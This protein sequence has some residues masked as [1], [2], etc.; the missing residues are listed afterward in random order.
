MRTFSYKLC[1]ENENTLLCSQTLSKD[2][3][4]Y[5]LMWKNMVETDKAQTAIK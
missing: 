3:A 5:E 4:V 1:R 2:Y